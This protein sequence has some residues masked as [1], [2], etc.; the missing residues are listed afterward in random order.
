MREGV[1][2]LYWRKKSVLIYVPDEV[3]MDSAF[4]F[5][6]ETKKVKIII[7]GDKLVIKKER[8]R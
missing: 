4:P 5:D 2:S 6:R 3:A 1:G 7:E 8:P